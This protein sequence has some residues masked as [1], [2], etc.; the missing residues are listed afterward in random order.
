VLFVV[1][2]FVSIVLLSVDLLLLT[3]RQLAAVGRAICLH[4]LVDSLFCGSDNRGAYFEGVL[5]VARCAR[6]RNY[7]IE[8]CA[9]HQTCI[10]IRGI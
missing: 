6:R 9:G 3:G 5:A 8:G 2:I 4:L 1:D 10:G 7:I